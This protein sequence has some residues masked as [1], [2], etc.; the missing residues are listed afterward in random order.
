MRSLLSKGPVSFDLKLQFYVD[1]RLTPIE[2]PTQIWPEDRTPIV[3]VG[4]LLALPETEAPPNFSARIESA[5]FDP[6]AALVEH[7]PLGEIMRA[8]KVA[9]FASQTARKAS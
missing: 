2:D 1:D 6:W 9:Y 7:R 4:R 3:T 8:R 5:S